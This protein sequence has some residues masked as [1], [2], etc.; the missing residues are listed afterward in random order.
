MQIIRDIVK[1]V[2]YRDIHFR[3]ENEV[4]VEMNGFEGLY[5]ISNYGRIMSMEKEWET[6]RN[7]MTRKRKIKIPSI[8]KGYYQSTL[9]INCKHTVVRIHRQV[10]LHFLSGPINNNVNHEDGNKLN[11]YSGNLSWVTVKENVA[12]AIENKLW[13]SRGSKSHLAKLSEAEV[14]IIKQ[15]TKTSMP[16][17]IIGERF[18]VSREAIQGIA[19]RRTWK[20]IF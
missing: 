19:T 4:F 8:S 20:H 2:N 13:D 14:K 1:D 5:L 3:Y 15:L 12:H 9:Y 7:I 17:R 18:G 6:G 10:A 11:N 16:R